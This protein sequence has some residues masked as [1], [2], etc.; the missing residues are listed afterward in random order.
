MTTFVEPVSSNKARP[1]AS[2]TEKLA[3]QKFYADQHATQ[4]NSNFQAET[5]TFDS[6]TGTVACRPFVRAV[7]WDTALPSSTAASAAVQLPSN[8]SLS[9]MV[10]DI[11]RG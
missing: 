10:E 8:E 6:N 7:N 1:S 11:T 3:N 4:N 2:P 9:N 5:R